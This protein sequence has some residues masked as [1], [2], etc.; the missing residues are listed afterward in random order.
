MCVW[1]G[2]ESACI[3][4]PI[5]F[6]C[7]GVLLC[8]AVN[9]AELEWHC[10][11]VNVPENMCCSENAGS[12]AAFMDQECTYARICEREKML[13]CSILFLILEFFR[14]LVSLPNEVLAGNKGW[15]FDLVKQ[16]R[17][18]SSY[19]KVSWV[20][21]FKEFAHGSSPV[22]L[23]FAD[24]IGNISVSSKRERVEVGETKNCSR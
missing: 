2:R 7:I 20:H 23:F 1:G 3:V 13:G 9:D 24:S 22:G 18:L 14:K 4:Y 5:L 6:A 17:D 11:W 8:W 16:G 12:L 19:Q 10:H 21:L 15:R